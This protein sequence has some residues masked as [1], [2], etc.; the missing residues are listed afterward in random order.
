MSVTMITALISAGA[1]LTVTM[2][3]MIVNLYIEVIRRKFETHQKT[4]QSKKENLSDVYKTLISIINRYPGSSPNDILKHVEYSPNYSMERYDTVLESLNYQ[5][6]DYKN[7]LNTVNIDY[8]RKNDIE[9]KISNL[10]YAKKNILENKEE[11]FVA[12][13]KYKLFC[14]GDKVAFDLY[15]GQEVRNLL[16]EFDVVI[17]NVFISGRYAGEDSDPINNIIHICRRNLIDSM[18]SDLGI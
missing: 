16:V 17:H 13:D 18:R 14:E 11:Y 15:A 4:I 3:T 7:Q 5:I 6:E 2:V 9:I 1:T 10:E 12:R 8:V